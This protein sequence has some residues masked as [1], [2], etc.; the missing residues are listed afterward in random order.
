MSKSVVLLVGKSGSGKTEIAKTLYTKG[1]DVLQSYT[2]RKPRSKN[3]WGHLFCST[4]EYEQF[5]NED[6]IVAYSY[7]DNNHYFSTKSQIYA[8]DIY[9]VDPDGVEDLKKNI[10]DINFTVI[11][12][13]VNANTRRN[14][15]HIRGDSVEMIR[16]RLIN[17]ERKFGNLKFDYAI[18]NNNLNKAIKIIEY[19]MELED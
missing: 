16:Q 17:D 11:Y 13:N 7:F 19:I 1:Y 10:E 3:E 18:P 9:V 12:L 8:T 5:K 4:D 6:D 14:R 15:M 2:T